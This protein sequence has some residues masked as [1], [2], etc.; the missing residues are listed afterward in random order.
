MQVSSWDGIWGDALL[1][2]LL[3]TAWTA[4]LD[5]VAALDDIG[6]EADGARTAVELQKKPAGIAEDRARLIA[7]PE[8]G[9]AGGAVL[10]DGLG[11]ERCQR[12]LWW[13]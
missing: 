3:A 13:W 1:T 11:S 8:R 4:S 5:A 2:Y 9:G 10:A 6:F 12:G 7:P